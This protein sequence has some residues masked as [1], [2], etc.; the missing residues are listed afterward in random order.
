TAS[1]TEK[2]ADATRNPILGYNLL[3]LGQRRHWPV[4]KVRTL[5]RHA[6][7]GPRHIANCLIKEKRRAWGIVH[8]PSLW[9]NCERAGLRIA[10]AV[11]S[12]R[13]PVERQLYDSRLS[14]LRNPID[15]GAT[16]D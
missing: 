1:G 10:R 3:V 15:Q 5:A 6:P 11:D 9:Y 13:C 2:E 16:R 8:S 7:H 12:S 14:S 4:G